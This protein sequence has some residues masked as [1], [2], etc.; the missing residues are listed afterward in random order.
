M[1]FQIRPNALKILNTIKK[2]TGMAT[3]AFRSSSVNSSLCIV[4]GLPLDFT[5]N[6]LQKICGQKNVNSPNT[7]DRDGFNTLS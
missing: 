1:D 3:R 7:H 6:S 2:N 4:S 5:Q